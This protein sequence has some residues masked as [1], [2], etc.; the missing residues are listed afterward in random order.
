MIVIDQSKHIFDMNKNNNPA[1]TCISGETVIFE[2]LDCFC[3]NFK[4][5]QTVWG[6]D[7]PLNSNPAT[8]PLYIENCKVGDTLK[9]EILDIELGKVGIMITG[10]VNQIYE[11]FF[12]EIKIN[13]LSVENDRVYVNDKLAL[14][15]RPMIGVIGVATQEPISSSLLGSHGGNLDC[16]DLI[17]GTTIYLPVFVT[18]G[19][20]SIGDLHA[21]MG[22]GEIGECGLEI[23][24]RVTVKVTV[25]K[26]KMLSGPLLEMD[27]Y[28]EII[29]FGSTLE[30]ASIKASQSM[31]RYMIED[32]KFDKHEAALLLNLC[33]NLKICQ[34]VNVIKSVAMKMPKHTLLTNN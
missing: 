2:T 18:G 27:D 7:N 8:G 32:L 23:D 9:I 4:H 5:P 20:L 14:L 33:G 24:G 31:L 17:K 16:N 29:E 21:L 28:I 25:I 3:N 15:V 11:D 6:K 26:N 19:L 30:E 10:S 13:R 12:D 1:S 22:D 34:Q